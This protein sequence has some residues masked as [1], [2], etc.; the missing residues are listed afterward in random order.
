M[1][2]ELKLYSEATCTK[3]LELSGL[4]YEMSIGASSGI[5]CRDADVIAT[6]DVWIKNVGTSP[7]MYVNVTKEGDELDSI[8]FA[9]GNTNSSLLLPL[10]SLATGAV[11]GFQIKLSVSQGSLSGLYSVSIMVRY[12]SVP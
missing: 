7:A 4:L 3:E 5:D 8:S 1:S 2:A 10:G 11:R 12:K 9:A 6:R